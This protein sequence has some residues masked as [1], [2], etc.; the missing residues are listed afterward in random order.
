MFMS[1]LKKRLLFISFFVLL[2]LFRLYSVQSADRKNIPD[3]AEVRIVARVTQQPYLKGS[4]QII[5]VNGFLIKTERFPTYFYG[6]K[7]VIVGKVKKR[8][9]NP[10]QVE[11]TLNYPAI[12]VVEKKQTLIS[13]IDL[14]AWLFGVKSSLEQTIER[15]LPEPQSSL[16]IGILLGSKRQ[17]P[18]KF[19]QSLRNTGTIHVIVASGYNITVIAGFLISGLVLFVNR[20]WA[21]ILAFLGIV[22][23]TIMAGAEP[24]IVRAAVMGSLTYLAQLLGRE[25]DAIV[26]LFFAATVMLLISPLIL[27]DIGFQLSF[28]ATAGILFIY[29]LLNGKIFKFP[30]L[31]DELRV[32]LSAQIAALPILLFNFGQVSFISP[33]INALVLPIVPLIMSLGAAVVGAGLLAKPLVQVLGWFVWV[34]LTYFVK[35]IEFFG[36]LPWISF[37]VG[38][39]NWVWVAGY[40][41]LL[42]LWILKKLRF[43]SPA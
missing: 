41:L 14:K 34:P 15:A 2:Y 8:V 35:L 37:S 36:Q 18:E 3:Q 27:F 9:I 32:T 38:E 10:F 30:L 25:K 26:C 20:R 16:L 13:K 29:P 31:G 19:L 1:G 40:Y 33:L 39:L 24:P 17:M 22:A 6:Q 12:Q 28:L 43:S 23:Y 4:N 11:F 5:N 42:S 21:L 7:L